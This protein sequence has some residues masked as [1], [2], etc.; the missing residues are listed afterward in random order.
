MQPDRLAD[1]IARRLTPGGLP[2]TVTPTEVRE[3]VTAAYSDADRESNLTAERFVIECCRP[4]R[5]PLA[6][7]IRTPR[8]RIRAAHKAWAKDQ[9]IAPAS[10]AAV[11]RALR[12]NGYREV[13]TTGA[14]R[15]KAFTLKLVHG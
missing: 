3:A 11:N 8:A 7:E 14:Q 12:R 6:G 5:D 2:A 9:G 1:A 10:P 15:V 4:W 13:Y